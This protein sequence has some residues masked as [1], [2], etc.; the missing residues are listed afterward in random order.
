VY[1]KKY[2]CRVCGWQYRQDEYDTDKPKT[3]IDR[4]GL[5][6]ECKKIKE[7]HDG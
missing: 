5:C 7:D 2:Y 4:K 1:K 6:K 3:E